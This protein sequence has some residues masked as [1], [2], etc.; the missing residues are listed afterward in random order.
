MRIT[1]KLLYPP[2]ML[3]LGRMDKS[4][5]IFIWSANLFGRDPLTRL[6]NRL[7]LKNGVPSFEIPQHDG[8]LD[9]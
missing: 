6:D 3:K 9:S 8:T 5:V 7:G 1:G 2:K 4:C